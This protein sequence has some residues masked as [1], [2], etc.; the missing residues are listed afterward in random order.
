MRLTDVTTIKNRIGELIKYQENESDRLETLIIMCENAGAY[1]TAQTLR[2]MLS[3]EVVELANL[4]KMER[5]FEQEEARL[6]SINPELRY[7]MV[8]EGMGTPY[9]KEP[10]VGYVGYMARENRARY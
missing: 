5:A 7:P 3:D 1:N 4:A 2:K 9:A 8:G 10:H 6:L